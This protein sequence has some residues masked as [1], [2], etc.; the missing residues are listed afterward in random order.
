MSRK[1]ALLTLIALVG[2]LFIGAYGGYLYGLQIGGEKM[3]KLVNIVYPQPPKEMYELDGLI[4]GTDAN[5]MTLEIQDPNDYLPHIDGT[6]STMQRRVVSITSTTK[7]MM[8]DQ[9]ALDANGEA[10]ITTIKFSDIKVGVRT[11]VKSSENIKDATSFDATEIE[12]FKN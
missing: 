12:V 4:V 10:I 1:T 11:I 9:N 8:A 7:I 5:T 6:D 2:T 3:Q